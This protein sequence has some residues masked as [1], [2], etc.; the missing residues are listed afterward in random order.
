M[1]MTETDH[2]ERPMRKS[3]QTFSPSGPWLVTADEIGDPSRLDIRLWVNDELRQ[4]GRLS[5]L[6]VDVPDLIARASA[7][8]E[9]GPGDVYSTGTPEGIGPIEVGDTVRI[10]SGR[11]GTMTLPVVRRPW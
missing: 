2:E 7:V 3:F 1:R 4:S 10:E 5:D 8:V 9:L 6:I 11:I